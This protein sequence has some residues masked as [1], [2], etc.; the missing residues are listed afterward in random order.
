MASKVTEYGIVCEGSAE[1]LVKKVTIYLGKGW[2]PTGGAVS[3][4]DKSGNAFF[5]QTL[6]R[7]GPQEDPARRVK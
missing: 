7:C 6:V 2:Q 5:M 3:A 4:M 1:K